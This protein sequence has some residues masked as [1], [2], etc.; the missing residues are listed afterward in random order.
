VATLTIHSSREL[1]QT[2]FRAV[3][4]MPPTIKDFESY[5][6]KGR[7]VPTALYLRL[8][9][10]SM[11]LTRMDLEH[12]RMKYRLPPHT[13]ELDLRLNT[14]IA[15]SLT[16][17]RTGHVEVWAPPEALLACVLPLTSGQGATI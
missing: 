8:T 7:L 14:R 10:L 13:A 1:K 16:N 9:G 12:A 17:P 2:V 15:F 5:A 3:E 4:T 6:A 11:Y